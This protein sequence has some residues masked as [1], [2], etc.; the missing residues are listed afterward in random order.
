MGHYYSYGPYGII[1]DKIN[2][3]FIGETRKCKSTFFFDNS[4]SQNEFVL[5]YLGSGIKAQ[6]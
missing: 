6:K 4:K 1:I 2:K 5:L 3:Q